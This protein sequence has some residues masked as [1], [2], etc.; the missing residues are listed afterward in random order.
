MPKVT[1]HKHTTEGNEMNSTRVIEGTTLM[2]IGVFCASALLSFALQTSGLM[3]TSASID[4]AAV[5]LPTV[6]ISG[7]RLNAEQRAAMLREDKL[8][9]AKSMDVGHAG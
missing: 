1:I 5:E 3:H 2:S 7:K 8:A 9:A 6:T 4:V